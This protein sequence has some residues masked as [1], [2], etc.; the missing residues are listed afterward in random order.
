MVSCF[1]D[2]VLLR[3]ESPLNVAHKKNQHS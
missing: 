1:I 2:L 3:F